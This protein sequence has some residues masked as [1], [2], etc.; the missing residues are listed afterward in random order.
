MK[1]AYPVEAP[2]NHA[3]LMGFRGNYF[4]NV[5]TV[6]QLGYDGIEILARDLE[7]I[8][9]E[10]LIRCAQENHVQIA[11]ISTAPI[12]K[13]DG[14]HLLDEAE[15]KQECIRRIEAMIRFASR[16]GAVV[17][18]GKARGSLNTA[19]GKRS[20]EKLQETVGELAAYA[21]RYAVSLAVEPQH[22][23]NIDNLNTIKEAMDFLGILEDKPV[24]VQPDLYHM[25]LSETD[26]SSA[27]QLAGK[28]IAFVHVSDS[29]RKILGKGN[30]PLRD[31]IKEI[32]TCSPDV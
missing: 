30:L 8:D 24:L 14:L 20:I 1:L 11:A 16:T 2:N 22:G 5:R 19:A 21:G 10:A 31:W 23:S 3:E 26:V 32:L 25:D 28:Q 15:K 9:Q 7:S 13:Q 17:L 4:E 12:D 18:L 29:E 6:A 27:I